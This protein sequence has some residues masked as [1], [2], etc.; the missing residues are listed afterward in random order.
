MFNPQLTR[1]QIL[2][3]RDQ[4]FIVY[5]SNENFLNMIENKFGKQAREN[6]LKSLEV[7]I[8]RDDL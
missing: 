3:F 8:T 1:R 4:A 6:I 2:D 7:K 5:H